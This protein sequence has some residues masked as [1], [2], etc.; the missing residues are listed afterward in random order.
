M[1]KQTKLTEAGKF[2]L[3]IAIGVVIT[4]TIKGCS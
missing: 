4:L 2:I 3:G 1:E